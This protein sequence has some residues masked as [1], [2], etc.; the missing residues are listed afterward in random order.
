[1]PK[2]IATIQEYGIASQVYITLF[3]TLVLAAAQCVAP[4]IR[5]GPIGAWDSERFREL[6][7]ALGCSL[8]GTPTPPAALTPSIG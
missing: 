2:T 4:D 5:R 1:M 3:D 7:K 8:A 6:A